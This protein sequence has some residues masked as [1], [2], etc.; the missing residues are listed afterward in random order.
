MNLLEAIKKPFLPK[1]QKY[2]TTSTVDDDKTEG[3]LDNEDNISIGFKDD[4][5]EGF[6]Q[7]K[8]YRKW[9]S[10]V[11]QKERIEEYRRIANM[12]DVSDGIDDIINESSFS[13][14]REEVIKM[15]I[16]E[17][18]EK[19]KKVLIDEFKIVCDDIL[20]IE[21]NIYYLL[22]RFYVDGQLNIHLNYKKNAIGEGIKSIEIMSPFFLYFDGDDNQWV[23]LDIK[24]GVIKEVTKTDEFFDKEEVIRIDSGI[25]EINEESKIILGWLEK[26]L[27]SANQ[28]STLEDLLI[29]MRYSRSV[30]RRVFIVDIGD[31]PPS[32]G[33]KYLN[34]VKNE[35][36]YKKF[37]NT[38]TGKI[39]NQ[40]HV[41]SMVEDYWFANRNGSRGTQVETI[42]E[43]GNLGE[44][45]DL[46]YFQKK[47]FRGMRIPSSR[48]LRDTDTP[49]Y[50]GDS[51]Q[52][53]Q[54]EMKFYLFVRRF[55]Q[56]F[57]T[58]IE[59]IF[60]RQVLS[61]KVLTVDE[62]KKYEKK[63]TFYFSA[64]NKFFTKL[65][66]IEL[67]NQ[68]D[69]YS[70]IK[71]DLGTNGIYSYNFVF[72]KIFNM[73]NDEMLER[74]KEIK[75]EEKSKELGHLYKEDDSNGF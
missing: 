41:A 32:K 74:F 65:K 8:R 23:Y 45:G 60:K 72:N 33:E 50:D 59:Q 71:D 5:P 56:R 69:M 38:E 20:N 25:Y 64:E 17:E 29:P 6:Y 22:E 55:R 7:N 37:Y 57:M 42:D 66:Q 49:T 58:L 9:A 13:D 11:K 2:T 35:F 26:V 3:N 14:Q 19:I 54:E 24:D 28:L 48:A 21:S 16:D 10:L 43:T 46:L 53:S 12:P 61:K 18:N 31:L 44:L 15:D 75:T 52:I 4:G 30:S 34:K 67:S 68:F 51:T 39:S 27:K 73:S 70:N 40:Q 62:Y 47:I 63:I 1:E 36:K